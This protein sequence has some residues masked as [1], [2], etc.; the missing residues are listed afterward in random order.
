MCTFIHI[1]CVIFAPV[2][3]CCCLYVNRW[4]MKNMCF[5]HVLCVHSCN[6]KFHIS[7]CHHDYAPRK[8]PP[9]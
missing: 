1:G 3:L 7:I 5:L 4:C 2:F 6:L 9:G 8:F